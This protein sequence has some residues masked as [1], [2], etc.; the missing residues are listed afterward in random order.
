RRYFILLMLLF[1]NTSVIKYQ[2]E[3]LLGL[4]LSIIFLIWEAWMCSYIIGSE[5]RLVSATIGNNVFANILTA[6]VCYYVHLIICKILEKKYLFLVAIMILAI[7]LTH[8]RSA[9]FIVTIYFILQAIRYMVYL[10]RT[11]PKRMFF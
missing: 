10:Y 1:A 8:T 2:K 3:L 4:S 7:A 11:Q 6:F 5:K 9:I